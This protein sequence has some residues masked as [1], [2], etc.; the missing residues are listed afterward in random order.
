MVFLN[1]LK[2]LYLLKNRH[3]HQCLASALSCLHGSDFHQNLP[4]PQRPVLGLIYHQSQFY[5]ISINT[6]KPCI[7]TS[8][9]FTLRTTSTF[10][11]FFTQSSYGFLSSCL[12]HLNLPCLTISDTDSMHRQFFSSS[13][14]T[15]Y[16]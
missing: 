6:L 10:E 9:L 1:F 3:H 7:L 15:I 8:I 14:I 13:D 16:S 4:S 12:I 5:H 11:H 2:F